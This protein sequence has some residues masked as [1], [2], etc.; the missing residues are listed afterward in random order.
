MIRHATFSDR[1]HW[2]VSLGRI[3]LSRWC[4]GAPCHLLPTTHQRHWV[5][6]TV[7][8]RSGSARFDT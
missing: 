6:L 1:R 5:R 4:P 8:R 2:E 3:G 7:Y